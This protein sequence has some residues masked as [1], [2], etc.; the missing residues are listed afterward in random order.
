M[1]LVE[2]NREIMKLKGEFSRSK[3]SKK[4]ASHRHYRDERQ[5]EPLGTSQLNAE[6]NSESYLLSESKRGCYI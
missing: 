6:R 3:E 2:R 4:S 5:V 1:Q